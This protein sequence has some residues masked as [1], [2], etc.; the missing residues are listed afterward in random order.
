M[1]T[2]EIELE[3]L[4]LE[5]PLNHSGESLLSLNMALPRPGVTHKTALKT[6]TLRKGKTN[7]ARAPFHQRGLLKEKVE[8][9]FGLHL[10]ITAPQAHPEFSRLLR[11]IAAVGVDSIGDLLGSRI[12]LSALRKLLDAPFDELADQLED[13]QPRFI[14]EGSLDLDSEALTSGELTIP[15]KLSETLRHNP[16]PPGPKSREGRKAKTITYKKGLTLGE[17]V[18]AITL[19]E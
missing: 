5:T 3:Q 1:Q 17:A 14:L 12:Q 6:I 2:I 4:K 15:L 10:Q 13:D 19:V 11:A 7:L 16:L 8:G 18:I 9:R